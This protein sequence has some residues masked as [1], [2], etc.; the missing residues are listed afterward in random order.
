MSDGLIVARG[1]CR[2]RLAQLEVLRMMVRR[3]DTTRCDT[4]ELKMKRR[5]AAVCLVMVWCPSDRAAGR[6]LCALRIA[7]LR[8]TSWTEVSYVLNERQ[9]AYVPILIFWT[10][11]RVLGRLQIDAGSE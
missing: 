5:G 7:E 2:Q 1:R 11:T 3:Y 6:S 8:Q 10:A 4:M 9:E